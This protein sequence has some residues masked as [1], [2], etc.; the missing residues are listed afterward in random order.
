[1]LRKF[2][3]PVLALLALPTIAS[4]QFEKGDIELTLSGGASANKETTAGQANVQGSVGYFLSNQLEVAVRQQVTYISAPSTGTFSG[5]AWGGETVAA[6]DYH[7]DMGAFQPF[8]GGYAGYLYPAAE[9]G[10]GVVAPEVGVKYFLNGTTF[11]F[12]S[13]AYEYDI[14]YPSTRSNF[15]GNLGIGVRL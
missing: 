10:S 12:A 13:V 4:A 3:V 15:F 14:D 5:V 9:N 6:V 7:F 8:V 2:V 1:M 11:V